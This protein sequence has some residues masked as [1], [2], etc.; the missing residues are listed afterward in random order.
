MASLHFQKKILLI[1]LNQAEG[2][3][4]AGAVTSSIRALVL[5]ADALSRSGLHLLKA[6]VHTSSGKNYL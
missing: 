5:P 4:F 1:K 3:L 2:F 6:G